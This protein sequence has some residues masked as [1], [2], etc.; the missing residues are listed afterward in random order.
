MNMRWKKGALAAVVVLLGVV[1]FVLSYAR[2][3]ESDKQYP[4]H[5]NII[6]T[7]FWVGEP[8]DGSNDFITN[9]SSTWVQDWAGAYGGTDDPDDRCGNNPCGF[10]PKENPFYAALPYNDL[11]SNCRPKDSRTAVYWF[12]GNTQNGESL[13]K[14]RWIQVKKGDK[15]AYAQVEDAGPFGEDDV[16]YVFGDQPPEEKRAGLDLSPAVADYLGIDGRAEV[17]WR[18]VDVA[19]VPQGEWTK[20]ITTSNPGC[21]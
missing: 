7:E 13:L 21:Q 10:T 16:G 6:A 5:N 9:V 18:F 20:K 17:S 11:N 12:Q 19:E 3:R 2:F 15:V 1:I 8:G 14:N 4:W